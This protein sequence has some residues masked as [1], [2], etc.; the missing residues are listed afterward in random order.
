MPE[1][2]I[3]TLSGQRLTPAQVLTLRCALDAFR[4]TLTTLGLPGEPAHSARL[5]Q[6]YLECLDE[7]E[8]LLGG[9]FVDAADAGSRGSG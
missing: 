9:P 1:E 6:R 8:V 3:I 7:L 4:T 5:E 2:P